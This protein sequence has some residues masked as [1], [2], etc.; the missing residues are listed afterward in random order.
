MLHVLDRV[1]H[2]LHRDPEH[3]DQPAMAR[4]ERLCT[5]EAR[6]GEARFGL[7][8]ATRIAE[9]EADGDRED[10]H[11]EVNASAS[12]TSLRAIVPR[13]RAPRRRTRR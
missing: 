5:P 12:R 2:E 10:V 1:A 13:R 6:L 8:D 3:E 11:Q 4:S 7:R 9:V